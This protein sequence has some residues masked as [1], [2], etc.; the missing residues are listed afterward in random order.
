QPCQ[1][2]D[3]RFA[4]A[5]SVEDGARPARLGGRG[6][7][8]EAP[9]RNSGAARVQERYRSQTTLRLH[10]TVTRPAGV[11][12]EERDR[13]GI[14]GIRQNRRSGSAPLR[15]PARKNIEPAQPAR[16]PEGS[17]SEGAYEAARV[18]STSSVISTASLTIAPSGS[19][20]S[21]KSFRLTRTRAARPRRCSFH[22]SVTSSE[23]FS[24]LRITSL[25]TPRIVRSPVAL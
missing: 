22:M 12:P 16:G 11:L 25:V 14:T 13:L 8:L 3:R 17:E 15:P 2:S 24:T 6:R 18:T 1:P 4:A 21:P 19:K 10:R 7:H 23:R 9:E 5:A 20:A